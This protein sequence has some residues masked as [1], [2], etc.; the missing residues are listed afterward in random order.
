MDGTDDI[1]QPI[2]RHN[3][4]SFMGPKIRSLLSILE[5]KIIK[6]IFYASDRTDSVRALAPGKTT[7]A[8]VIFS[9]TIGV[10]ALAFRRHLRYTGRAIGARGVII[11]VLLYRV[12]IHAS[13]SRAVQ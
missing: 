1:G 8:Q 6:L 3:D 2:G 7:V 4:D 10:F 12:L 5:P 11:G 13:A 9:E